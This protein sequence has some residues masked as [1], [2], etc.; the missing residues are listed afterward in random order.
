MKVAAVITSPEIVDRETKR[1]FQAPSIS[2]TSRP[3]RTQISVNTIEV[4]RSTMG[5]AA[6]TTPIVSLSFTLISSRYL[7]EII[8][9]PITDRYKVIH[10]S[11]ELTGF[12]VPNRYVLLFHDRMADEIEFKEFFAKIHS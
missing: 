1:S 12:S 9:L 6:T 3:E 7:V 5:W 2:G 11:G 4:K 8:L 10:Q